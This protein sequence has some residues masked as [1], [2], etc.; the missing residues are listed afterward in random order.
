MDNGALSSFSS[1]IDAAHALGLITV[2]AWSRLVTIARIR[3]AFAH[4]IDTNSLDQDSIRKECIDLHPTMPLR[5][6]EG[7]AKM[8]FVWTAWHLIGEIARAENAVKRL[9]DPG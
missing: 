1:R 6:Q 3:N 2:D 4:R 8:I 5:D 9:A 7:Y